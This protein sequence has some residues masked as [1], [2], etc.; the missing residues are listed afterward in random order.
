MHYFNKYLLSA[1]LLF[2]GWITSGCAVQADNLP[3]FISMVKSS[4]PAVVNV[5]TTAKTSVTSMLPEQYQS[6][7]AERLL[8]EM[9]KRFFK[10]NGK[11]GGGGLPDLDSKA[12]GSGFILSSDGYIVTNHHVVEE[13]DE[14]I[15]K[16][17]DRREFKAKL[18]GSDKRTDVALLKV[19]STNLPT[20][21]I[22]DS[23]KLQ[24]GE[25][26]LAIGSPFG[27]E[28]SATAGIV[29]ATGRNLPTDSYVPFIQTDVAI[30][31]GNSGG[32]LFNLSGE[33]I[34]INSQ[35]FSRSGGYMGL[36]FSIP[37]NMAMGVVNQL[38]TKGKVTRGWM[39][40]FIQEVD[41][42][43]ARSFGM[44]TPSGALVAQV[45]AK[46]P[47]V[48]V[49]HEGDVVV[50]VNGQ[51]V[52][53]A[54]SLPA[55]VGG[56]S[57]GQQV[58]VGILRN[59]K[60]E[61]VQITIGELPNE[62]NN[63]FGMPELKPAAPPP[64]TNTLGMK[65]SPLDEAAKQSLGGRDGVL[66]EEVLGNPAQQVGIMAGDIILLLDGRSV[67]SPEQFSKLASDFP[68][69]K[70]VPMLIQRNGAARFLALTIE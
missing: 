50:D 32:P 19:E 30:N 39:G 29:S 56:F 26:V 49:L 41:Q 3:D 64:P 35:I 10:D 67:S 27:L 20:L 54:A 59:G 65:L 11:G 28:S 15:V 68:K 55:I 21:K 14:I 9:L 4:S 60:R 23:S 12:S 16:L 61:T 42:D 45:I 18:V 46:G 44:L 7:E 22:G 33:V 48:N 52:A 37:I 6:P 2:C 38:K 69:G 31:P 62:E 47:A 43:L 57:A 40:V 63:G 8:D 34:G 58:N 66:V 53:S 5:S 36:S 25:W 51:A 13:A 24:V 17:H 70:T 1:C